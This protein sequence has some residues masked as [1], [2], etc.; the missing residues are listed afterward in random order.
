MSHVRNLFYKSFGQ[1]DNPS[2]I[3]MPPGGVAIL[4]DPAVKLAAAAVASAA[5]ASAPAIAAADDPT[6]A[7]PPLEDLVIEEAD[8]CAESRI[9][10]HSDPRNA[11]SN[12]FR[13]LRMRLNE[14][15]DNG[16]L[17]KLL[18]TGP[19][20]HEGKST[21]TLNLASALSERGKRR[22]L[23][24]DADMHHSS[25]AAKLS[26]RAWAGLNEC[27]H[28]SSMPPLSAVRRI[29]PLGWYFLPAGR[30][31]G[32]PTELLQTSA[33]SVVL[34][35]LTPYFDWILID[36]PPVVLLTD[37]LSIQQHVDATIVVVRAGQTPRDAV[38]KTVTL[39]GKKNI[40]SIV[41]NGVK[42]RDHS[43]A[44]YYSTKYYRTNKRTPKA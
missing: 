8:V 29:E 22:V 34:Q 3:S 23:V 19:L 17:K 40:V 11:A 37:A 14:L 42:S 15:S 35:K 13:L 1:Q 6:T 31:R 2:L 25:L 30:A 33:L 39:L 36:S 16:K 12:R 4:P 32:N 21:V 26:L 43:Y 18:I 38:E 44:Q 24:V 28:D 20:T 9:I 7:V 5:V 41:L 10:Y 27:L